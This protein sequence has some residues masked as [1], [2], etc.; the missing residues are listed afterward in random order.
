MD[1]F[2]TTAP[3]AA[4]ASHSLYVV[5]AGATGAFAGQTHKLAY[6]QGGL[7]FSRQPAGQADRLQ[8][9]RRGLS[10]RDR[11]VG[12]ACGSKPEVDTFLVK[13]GQAAPHSADGRVLRAIRSQRLNYV[14]AGGTANALTVTLD[15]PPPSLAAMEGMRAAH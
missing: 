5:P 13:S 11:R 10:P 14:V 2:T 4:P 7:D 12:S 9:H 8:R 6:Y 15:P 1:S 3:P